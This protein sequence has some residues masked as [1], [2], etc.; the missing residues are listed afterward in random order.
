[1][2][3]SLLTVNEN[4]AISTKIKYINKISVTTGPFQLLH[5]Y[6]Y[7]VKVRLVITVIGFPVFYFHPNP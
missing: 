5:I 3:K 6:I 4:T 2:I 7:K 1:M